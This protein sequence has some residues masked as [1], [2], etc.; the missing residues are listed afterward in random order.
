MLQTSESPLLAGACMLVDERW[1]SW[2][3][4]AKREGVRGALGVAW[5]SLC[6]LADVLLASFPCAA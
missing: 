2:G 3:P 4:Q 5:S 1:G 6:S